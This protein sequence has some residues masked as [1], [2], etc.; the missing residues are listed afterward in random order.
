MPSTAV[1]QW[2]M[3]TEYR[4][5]QNRQQLHEMRGVLE[6]LATG[7]QETNEHLKEISRSVRFTESRLE[8]SHEMLPPDY[9]WYERVRARHA[10]EPGQA[11]AHRFEEKICNVQVLRQSSKSGCMAPLYCLCWWLE[12]RLWKC[13][14]D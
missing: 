14:R 12:Y 13:R 7:Q 2:V 6:R 3:K 8:D 4:C 9:L 5:Q 1:Q 11:Y 10:S